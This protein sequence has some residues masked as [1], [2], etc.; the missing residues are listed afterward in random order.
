V[1]GVATAGVGYALL[2]TIFRRFRTLNEPELMERMRRESE[3]AE[4]QGND[5]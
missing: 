4:R 5:A 2:V 1:V 3:A